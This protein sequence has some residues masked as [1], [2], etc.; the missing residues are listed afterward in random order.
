[1]RHGRLPAKED[2]LGSVGAVLALCTILAIMM[3]D[4]CRAQQRARSRAVGDEHHR[5]MEG[6]AWHSPSSGECS[7]ADV[8]A[9]QLGCDR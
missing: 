8:P 4:D 6:T 2:A 1:M 5:S 3:M 9:R 7:I